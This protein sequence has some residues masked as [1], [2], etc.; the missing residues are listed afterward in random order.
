VTLAR[1]VERGQ[2][3]TEAD[4]TW[5]DD[6]GQRPTF[7]TMSDMTLAV[8]QE[9]RRALRPGQPLRATDVQA[10]RVVRRGEILTLRYA[11][12]ALQLTV[13][14]RALADAGLGQRVRVVNTLSNR[15]LEA[16]VSGPGVAW[17]GPVSAG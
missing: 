13:Q 6:V 12:G 11:T 1:A 14:A 15:T 2:V 17:V 10:A 7:Q 3:L 4:L 5:S 8:G 9:A 16:T